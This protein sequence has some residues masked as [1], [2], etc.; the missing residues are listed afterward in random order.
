MVNSVVATLALVTL[1][2]AALYLSYEA[3]K[4]K[5][6][7]EWLRI[8]PFYL[9][10]KS[11]RFND[12]LKNT[13]AKHSRILNAVFDLGALIGYVLMGLAGYSLII[14]LVNYLKYQDK[15]GTVEVLI[16]GVTISMETFLKMI[17]AIVIILFSH[18]LFH[19]IALHANG[20]PVKKVGIFIFYLI[21]GAFVEPDEE[22]FTSSHP[23]VKMR[24]L[25]AGSLINI[26]IGLSFAPLALNE[27]LYNALISPFYSEPSGV[28]VKEIIPG[29]PMANQ[30]SIKVGDVITKINNIPIKNVA[31][32]KGINLKPGDKA[33]IEY[34]DRALN[35]KRTIELTAQPDPNNSS[36]GI[37]GYK[38]LPYY[39][40]KY[41]FLDPLMP[42][43]LHEV[44]FWI[45][46]LNLNVAVFNM[47]PIAPLDGYGHLNALIEW[48]K[49]SSAISKT[50]SYAMLITYLS[51]LVVNVFLRY[52]PLS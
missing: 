1:V 30:S 37:L 32:V 38:A 6:K 48:L 36:R 7:F 16:P 19:K 51:L 28:L 12:I 41:S 20:V 2:W 43:H 13:S 47:M 22:L 24:V 8:G 17:P 26:L 18:E 10:V 42:I 40:P 27:G 35:E 46:F 31:D 52:L 29:S 9:M 5:N 44:L 11:K 33:V 45:F 39:P 3:L 21:P 50:I 23:K 4:L 14:A 25:A 49:V 15:V 34:L